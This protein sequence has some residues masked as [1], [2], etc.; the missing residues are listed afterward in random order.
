M[1]KLI[2]FAALLIL[3]V[4]AGFFVGRLT[5]AP[6]PEEAAS[7]AEKERKILYWQAP[8]NPTEIYDHPG[9]SSMGM[10]LVPV[11]ADEAEGQATGDR[12]AP[13]KERK[14]LYWQA[15]MNP[16]E[17]Y[18][19]PGK[20]SMG[21]DL[22]PV[23]EDEAGLGSG[24]AVSI[25]PAVVQNMGVR[26][27]R[28]R[29]MDFSRMIR[30]VGEVQ[31]DEERVYV[32][33]AKISGWIE[34]LYVNFVGD[35]LKVGD[36]LL[37]IYSP[38]LVT[39]QEEYLLALKNYRIAMKSTLPE[40]REDAEKLLAS[41][42]KRLEYW[43]IPPEEIERLEQTREIKKTILLKAPNSGVVVQQNA[44]EGAFLKA[45]QDLFRVADLRTVWVH[46]SFYDN[47]VPWINVGQRVDMELSYLPGKQYTG[48]ISY[49]Y[50]YLREKSRDVHVRVIFA[51]PDLD[52]KPGMYA[53]VMLTGKTIPDALVIPTEA[54]IHSGERTIVFVVRG[55]G[56][57]EPREV[58]LGE[59]GGPGNNYVRVLGGLLDGEEIVISAQF[60]IDSE[61]RLQEAIQKMLSDRAKATPPA[62][63]PSEV[64]PGMDES[65]PADS[66]EAM[67]GMDESA[68]ADAAEA[69]PGMDESTPAATEHQH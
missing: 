57:F 58:K 65:A 8:M 52:L 31:Y 18:D 46:A 33:N 4:A 14:I 69:M 29:R 41:A 35:E 20:S 17:I 19:H 5:T 48:R 66:T 44:T 64:M 60:L 36:P 45:G 26:T 28:V 24:G 15:P 7:T 12:E 56:K 62:V 34:K 51:N 1:K 10:D 16:T 40:A 55:E 39:T 68:P 21:M 54:V 50:P 3:A 63:E 59:E 11:Y 6:A 27:D 53:N 23:Y 9:K 13:K 37:E 22:I 47:E 38:E 30:T 42:R 2:L 43:D 61:S 25:D 32:V 49:I 67:P